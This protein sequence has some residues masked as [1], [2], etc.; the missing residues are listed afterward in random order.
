MAQVV[1]AK[2]Y[3]AEARQLGAQLRRMTAKAA[4]LKKAAAALRWA[5]PAGVVLVPC[6]GAALGRH[7]RPS[8]AGHTSKLPFSD[9]SDMT[10]A[11]PAARR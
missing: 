1:K 10:S 7:G 2:A 11:L 8:L 9:R 6:A 4:K 3:H 5:E